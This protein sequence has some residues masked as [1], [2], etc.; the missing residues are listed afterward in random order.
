MPTFEFYESHYA[1]IVL[2]LGEEYHNFGYNYTVCLPLVP[3]LYYAQ[4]SR[5]NL[6]RGKPDLNKERLKIKAEDEE[7]VQM[8]I[9]LY[10]RLPIPREEFDIA[11]IHAEVRSFHSDP[12]SRIAYR[13]ALR[14]DNNLDLTRYH[15]KVERT[16][17]TL[18]PEII[19]SFAW[20]YITFVTEKAKNLGCCGNWISELVERLREV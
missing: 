4:T 20:D 14:E 7:R 19:G 18:T 6:F 16:I 15:D 2:K 5:A 12:G 10:R 17:M 8:S 13:W 3:W 9:E 1:D 11:L